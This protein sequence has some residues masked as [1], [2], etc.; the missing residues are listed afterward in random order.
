MHNE[1]R[2]L[3]VL[4][5]ILIAC[6]GAS[7]EELASDGDRGDLGVELQLAPGVTLNTVAW[8]VSHAASGFSRNGSVNVKS[9]SSLRFRVGGLPTGSGYT[10]EL[11]ATSADGS[12]NC[13][14]FADFTVSAG[15]PVQ[16]EVTLACSRPARNGSIEVTGT[17]Q[18]CATIDSLDVS[19]LDAGLEAPVALAVSALGA[20][21]FA[22]TASAGTFSDPASATP[23]F[24]CPATP[25][26]V[27]VS[28][29]ASPGGDACPDS[30][31]SLEIDCQPLPATFTNVYTEV[32]AAR[33]TGCH[34]PGGPGVS[35]GLL[36]MSTQAVAYASLVGVPAAG[37][38]AGTSGIACNAL[39]PAATRVVAG[40]ADASI[41]YDK[42]QSKV[43]GVQPECGSVMPPGAAAP[44]T[45]AQIS[46]L[47][48][49][50]EAGALDD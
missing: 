50:I 34:R 46:L 17:T 43:E 40:D 38:A 3:G 22:W 35:G 36:D 47:A 33:C 28:V 48:A 24:T 29:A 39:S 15:A 23:T 41:L 5:T 12:F 7:P 14:G 45:A 25:G 13:S 30:T 37:T 26:V 1:I 2:F 10:L 16:V 9:S 32:L 19:S 44:L 27:S 20:T 11:S 31:A 6:S 42:V 18:I 21:A 4:S 8:S 49:W